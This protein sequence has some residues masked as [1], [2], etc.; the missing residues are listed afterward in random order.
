MIMLA[1]ACCLPAYLRF[2]SRKCTPKRRTKKK[3]KT[4]GRNMQSIYS[5]VSCIYFFL[6]FWV[7]CSSYSTCAS[8]ELLFFRIVEL[9]IKTDRW[10]T[11]KNWVE[12]R[13]HADTNII[14][15]NCNCVLVE[16]ALS[17]SSSISPAFQLACVRFLCNAYTLT[18]DTRLSK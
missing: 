9:K 2:N 10:D 1:S 11:T 16:W 14:V 18:R 3:K 15:E 5:R 4:S 13:K 17:K 6:F 8:I 12:R 7:R